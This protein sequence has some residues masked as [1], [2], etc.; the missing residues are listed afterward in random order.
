MRWKLIRRR[1]SVSAP[2]MII[3]SHLPWPLR[4]AVAALVLGFSAALALWAFEFGREI[5]GVEPD[6]SAALAQLRQEMQAL[7]EDRDRAQS[8]A[9]AADGLLKAERAA[10]D[11]L[12]Q[13]LRQA[14][15]RTQALEADLGFFERLLPTGTQPL[16]LRALHV[17]TV[18]PGQSRY[19]MLMMQSGK[20]VT[21]FTGRYDIVLIGL[22]DGRPWR[23]ALPSGPQP[24]T[25]RQYARI[26]GMLTHPE[27]AVLKTVQATVTDLNGH[28]RARET[29]QLP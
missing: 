28:V 17:E 11:R 1:L 20:R 15:A 23:Q 25:L 13:A 21:E 4:W 26:E 27:R 12:T 7:R 24:L 5:A 6:A 22:L 29:V 3:R 16:Q 14:E 18:A 2:R 10:Q 19:Q 8:I 9:N